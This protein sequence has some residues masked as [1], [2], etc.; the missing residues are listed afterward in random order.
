MKRPTPSQKPT[1]E[2]SRAHGEPIPWRVYFEQPDGST[3]SVVVK[4]Q[5][6][7]LARRAGSLELRKLPSEVIVIP[8]TETPSE[9]HKKK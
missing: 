4:E 2:L 8:L 6:A 9:E 1:K 3:V 5:T 7:F